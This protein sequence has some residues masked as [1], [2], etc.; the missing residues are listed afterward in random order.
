LTSKN[1]THGTGVLNH[2]FSRYDPHK[3]KIERSRKG[4]LIS[5]SSGVT[6]AHALQ[7]IEPRGTLF[8]GAN[9][10]VYPGMVRRLG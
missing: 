3:G 1:D 4:A 8:V 5:S 9:V 10:K 2:I 6:T 7:G